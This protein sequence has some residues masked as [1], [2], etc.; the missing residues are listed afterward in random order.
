MALFG[1]VMFVLLIV[2]A[3]L[4]SLFLARGLDRQRQFAMRAALGA[5]RARLLRENLAENLTIALI[6]AVAGF[7]FAFWSAQF[8]GT[9]VP[10]ALGYVVPEV[11]ID[12]AAFF[13]CITVAGAC[14]LVFVDV[15]FRLTYW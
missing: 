7:G 12:K 10:D 9:L 14:A 11:S 15:L 2:C 5:S 1:A 3:N 13:F 8:L 4:A 6:G